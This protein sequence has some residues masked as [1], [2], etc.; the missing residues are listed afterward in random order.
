MNRTNKKSQ[1]ARAASPG[2]LAFLA[3]V[4]NIRVYRYPSVAKQS[5]FPVVRGVQAQ[6]GQA[7]VYR[8]QIAISNA[9]IHTAWAKAIKV[10]RMFPLP[11]IDKRGVGKRI[12]RYPL[13]QN[14]FERR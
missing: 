8:L 3:A 7:S 1:Q 10:K 2:L 13:R 5:S 6:I 12:K 11:A 9:M 4:G 14:G